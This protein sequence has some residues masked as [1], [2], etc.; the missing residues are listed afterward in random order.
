MNAKLLLV[1]LFAGNLLLAGAVAYVRFHPHALL[2]SLTITNQVAVPNNRPVIKAR[3]KTQIIHTD[4]GP[5]TFD[6]ASLE[7]TD[8]KAYIAGLHNLECPEETIRDI[9]VAEVNKLY[10]DKHR[11]LRGPRANQYWKTDVWNSKEGR[12]LQKKYRDLEKEKSALLKELL[13]V[14]SNKQMQK[15]MGGED[16]WERMYSFLPEEKQGKAREVQEKY[17]EMLQE[18]WSKGMQDEE[19][20]KE[21]FK[22]YRLQT[23][24]MSRFMTPAELDHY[25]LRSSQVANQ[26]RHDL[27]G[28]EPTEE[29]FRS[30]YKARKAREEDLIYDLPGDPDDKAAQERR[31]KAQKEV[32]EQIKTLV[33]DE[34]YVEYKRA[35][36]WDYKNLLRLTERQGLPREAAVTVY[37]MRKLVEEQV[38]K[39]RADKTL[40]SEQRTEALKSIRTETEKTVIDTLGEKV[41]ASYKRRGGGYWINNISPTRTPQ[42]TAP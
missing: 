2:S 37:D 17:Q 7:S 6:W 26:L 8:F 11:T 24:E 25:E 35:Q 10:G 21:I 9:I 15:E 23:E 20:K 13:G 14:D 27:D 29:E 36:D 42:P 5:A 12:D 40:T 19:D 16:Y 39:V 1:T 32:D 4:A 28:F 33:G 22:I 38:Q 3:T 31:N 34:R 18:I 41:S 30:I